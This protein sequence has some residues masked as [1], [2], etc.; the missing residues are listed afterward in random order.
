MERSTSPLNN[1]SSNQEYQSSKSNRHPPYLRGKAIGLWYAGQHRSAN[2]NKPSRS[3]P[4]PSQPVATIE[5]SPNELQRV[6]EVRQLFNP[7]SQSRKNTKGFSSNI[8]DKS[9]DD[10]EHAIQFEKL[11][12][13]FQYFEP[14]NRNP[15][16]DENLLND[17]QKKQSSSLCK[18]LNITRARLP[19]TNYR[20]EIL[21]TAEQ[22]QIFVLV[23]ETGSGKKKNFSR[24]KKIEFDSFRKNNTNSSIY[25]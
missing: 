11:H 23:G 22:N 15:E 18:K 16:I 7:Q 14:L 21:T 25:S 3:H 19:I 1:N 12:S 2:S 10:A 24:N 9:I 8:N 13:S 20:Q 6:T 17:L 4:P 5:L